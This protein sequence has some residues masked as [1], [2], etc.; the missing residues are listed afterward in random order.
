MEKISVVIPTYNRQHTLL[1]A[2][3]SVLQQ[4][5]SE[6]EI[7][8]IDDGSTDSTEEI[9]R[10]IEDYRVRYIPLGKNQGVAN[11][12]NFG[13][14]NA[15]GEWIAFQDSDDSWHKDK[16]EKQMDY[17]KKHPEYAMIYTLYQANLSDGRQI[18]SPAK[19]WPPVMEGNMFNTLLE[20]NVIGAPTMCVK[21]ECFLRSGGFDT[22]YKSLEDWEY[23]LRF[24]RDYRIGFIPEALMDV[25][26][27][28]DGIS[29]HAGNYFESRCRMLAA[30]KEEMIQA[31]VF[32]SVA[33]DILKRA[34]N[35]NILENVQ[36]M[37]MLY[38]Q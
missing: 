31:G 35:M 14:A 29:S 17:A 23:A 34:Q 27:L 36:N 3:N 8:I 37:M 20:R 28:Q 12:R 10:T 7:L 11:A 18:I 24:S 21:R 6:L 38:L 33:M 16:L 25:Y 13:V 26:M 19:P 22:T 5:Y 2:V 30:F 4:S 32:D 1:R 15:E 9:V